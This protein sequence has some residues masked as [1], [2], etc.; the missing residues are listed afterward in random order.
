M[1]IDIR[2]FNIN[3]Q[4]TLVETVHVAPDGTFQEAGDYQIPGVEGKSSPIK[5]A[6]LKP[7]GSMTGHMFPSGKTTES[8]TIQSRTMGKFTVLVSLVDAA[9]PFVLVDTSSLDFKGFRSWPDV[10]DPDFLDVVEE[11]RR[12]GAV[13]LGLARDVVTAGLVRGTPKIAFLSPPVEDEDGAD[14]QVLAFSLGKPHASLQLT[15][16]VCIGAAMAIHG[17]IAWELAR[18][19]KLVLQPKHGMVVEGFEIAA[20]VPVGIRHPAGVIHAE[21]LL[22]MD[23][24]GEIEVHQVAVFRTARR[25]FAGNVF[26]RA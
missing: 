18:R 22:G 6:F 8:L 15:G 23:R 16:A 12:Q 3:T 24:G 10:K 4:Q 26:Y 25:L 11:I 5:V 9:N 2:I 7:G 1:K 13:Q 17:T 14:L 21:T 19:S 20:P